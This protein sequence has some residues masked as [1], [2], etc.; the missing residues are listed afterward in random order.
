MARLHF[1]HVVMLAVLA[2]TY[3]LI[4]KYSGDSAT[5]PARANVDSHANINV[6]ADMNELQISD[7]ASKRSRAQESLHPKKE[8]PHFLDNSERFP[9][10]AV[11]HPKKKQAA[12]PPPVKTTLPYSTK[13]TVPQDFRDK[14]CVPEHARLMGLPEDALPTT[15]VIFCFCNE[16]TKS[17]YHSIHSVIERSPRHLLHEIVLVD[18]GSDAPHIG[19]PLEDYV[20]TLPVPV[21]IV[22]QKGRTGL[23]RARVAGA[24]AATGTTLTFLDSHISCSVGWLEPLM[25]RISQDRRHIVMPKIDGADRDFNYH[26]G[27]IELVGFNTG[28]VDH[29]MRLQHKDDFEGRTAIHPQPSPAMAGG[30]FS[31]HREYFFEIGAFDEKMAHWGGENI[32]IG[33]RAWQCGGTIELIPCSRVAHVFGGMGHSCG[34]PGPPPGSINKWRAIETW[35]DNYKPFFEIFM[36]HPPA[37]IGDLTHMK[38]LRADLKCKDFEWFVENVYPEGWLMQITRAKFQGLLENVGSGKCY[39]P[40]SQRARTTNGGK[41]E[42]CNRD[43]GFKGN[44]QYLWLTEKNELLL[45]PPF[46]SD[47]IDQCLDA[48][49]TAGSKLQIYGC[50]GFGGKQEW[51][52]DPSTLQ[53]KHQSACLAEKDGSVRVEN[54]VDDNTQKWKWSKVN[55]FEFPKLEKS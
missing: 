54:C 46:G 21:V 28:L 55:G 3:V 39:N 5:K 24:R 20:K 33:F 23:M 53:I 25:F 49:Q 36:Q 48:Y 12:M 9:V 40:G 15:S 27:G 31:V 4:S 41:M 52:Y 13:L 22:R 7:A 45:N 38:Q 6:R 34:W 43:K 11:E 32:E 35:T 8:E 19:K 14:E 2:M 18:D 10:N 1:K 29:G 37:D 42:A 30:L 16:P 47:D 17:L 50:H 51:I 26:R 44:T